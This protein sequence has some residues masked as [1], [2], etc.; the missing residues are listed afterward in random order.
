[1]EDKVIEIKMDD[2]IIEC[3]P[4]EVNKEELLSIF[5]IGSRSKYEHKM[6]EFVENFLKSEKIEYTKDSLGNIYNLDYKD[7]PM[8]CAHM[9]TV[10]DE[11]DEFGAKF[12]KIYDDKII[13]SYGVLG[14]DDKCGIYICMELLRNFPDLNFC[15]CVQE[16]N[17]MVGSK[18]VAEENAEKLK[19]ISYGLIFDR[20]GNS[21]IICYQNDY[22]TKDF[23]NEIEKIGVF[24]GY[25]AER[26]M[27]SDCNTFKKFFSCCN[28]S[29][30][31]Y[32][33]HSKNEYVV[34]KD[35]EE[36]LKFG[37]DILY[38]ITDSFEPYVPTYKKTTYPSNYYHKTRKSYGYND[39]DN[40]DDFGNTNSFGDDYYYDEY[41]VFHLRKSKQKEE[42]KETK[43]LKIVKMCDECGKYGQTIEIKSLSNLRICKDCVKK[44]LKELLRLSFGD[45]D[46]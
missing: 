22:G 40:I 8:V 17:G 36:A 1:M 44:I 12:A 41:G 2:P 33:P 39:F 3:C 11:V 9:D 7:S 21:D 45:T 29:C 23:E 32:N 10:Q 4:I 6:V 20:R 30:G 34:I 37:A 38:N 28:L 5:K 43:K 24:W 14:G 27:S 46:D 42:E 19:N 13:R 31:Y 26:G 16:E 35:L 15:F 18:L 25:K